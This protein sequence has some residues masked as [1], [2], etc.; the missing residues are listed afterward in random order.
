MERTLIIV[1]YYVFEGLISVVYSTAFV[2]FSV[3]LIGDVIVGVGVYIGLFVLLRGDY[4]RL[5]V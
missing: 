4:G 1:S 5:I 2:Y 3:V